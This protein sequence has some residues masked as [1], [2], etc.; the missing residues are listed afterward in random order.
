MPTK[1]YT[2]NTRKLLK[3]WF[4]LDNTQFMNDL[5]QLRMVRLRAKHKES[6]ITLM[7]SSKMLNPAAQAALVHFCQTHRIIALDFDTQLQE[8]IARVGT[9]EEKKLYELAQLELQHVRENNFG[10]VAAAADLIRLPRPVLKHGIYT[11][12]D[13]EVDFSKTAPEIQI[14]DPLLLNAAACMIPDVSGAVNLNYHIMNNFIGLCEPFDAPQPEGALERLQK[15]IISHYEQCRWL[16]S[17][18]TQDLVHFEPRIAQFIRAIKPTTIFEMRK[19]CVDFLT[20]EK[21]IEILN[22][23]VIKPMIGCYHQ[24]AANKQLCLRVGHTELVTIINKQ[25]KGI[26]GI[27]DIAL[28]ASLNAKQKAVAYIHRIVIQDTLKTNR[29]ILNDKLFALH[30]KKNDLFDAYGESLLMSLQVQLVVRYSGP[31]NYTIATAQSPVGLTPRKAQALAK[32]YG[33]S[34]N[35]QLREFTE[36]NLD[37]VKSELMTIERGMRSDVSWMPAGAAVVRETEQKMSQAAGV[38]QRAYR[39]SRG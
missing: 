21:V 32:Q 2:L 31:T 17:Q 25:L 33:I 39:R 30:E 7:Y 38:I 36:A 20:P 26:A 6:T 15:V 34:G 12:L 3:V 23:D 22:E 14:N 24:L 37:V 9:P 27:L 28:D 8:E 4:S 19:L 29:T 35:L 5:N 1:T 18:F 16:G 11:D 13:F 10:S